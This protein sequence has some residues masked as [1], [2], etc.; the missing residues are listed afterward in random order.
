MD[1]GWQNSER[2]ANNYLEFRKRLAS[3]VDCI[4]HAAQG[5][6]SGIRAALFLFAMMISLQMT[7]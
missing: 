6:T 3:N 7:S 4:E 1:C 5:Q 2:A